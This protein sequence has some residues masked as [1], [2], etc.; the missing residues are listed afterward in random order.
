MIP[1][2]ARDRAAP[3]RALHRIY[4]EYLCENRCSPRTR[5]E[6]TWRQEMKEAL[7]RTR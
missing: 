2:G 5:I 4:G 3:Q 1:A 6:E 7:R